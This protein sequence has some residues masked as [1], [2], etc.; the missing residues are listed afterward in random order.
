MFS[1]AIT[2]GIIILT[3]LSQ[4][5]PVAATPAGSDLV[6]PSSRRATQD[7]VWEVQIHP[8]GPLVNVTGTVQDVIRYAE[9]INPNFRSDFAIDD[10]PPANDSSLVARAGYVRASTVQWMDCDWGYDAKLDLIIDG[11]KYLA[12]VPGRPSMGWNNGECAIVSCDWGATIQWCNDMGGVKTLN[13]YRSI[14]NA[15]YDLV[16]YCAGRH[17]TR[18]TRGSVYFHDWSV[19][20][21]QVYGC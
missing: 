15:A 3:S 10:Q 5:L 7:V 9:K 17:K 6:R 12:K 16:K 2:F 21:S 18:V 8:G 4:I 1:S 11:M 19:G 13:S 14:A 20:V